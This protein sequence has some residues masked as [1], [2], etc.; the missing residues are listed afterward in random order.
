[1]QFWNLHIFQDTAIRKTDTKLVTLF[2]MQLAYE[3][4]MNYDETRI[5]MI[6]LNNLFQEIPSAEK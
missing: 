3:F 4:N 1:M 2:T 6:S 5:S